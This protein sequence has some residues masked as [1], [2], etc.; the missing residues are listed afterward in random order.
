MAQG[1]K[2]VI[3]NHGAAVVLVL[4]LATVACGINESGWSE[5][6]IG[7]RAEFEAIFFLDPQHGL[8]VGGDYF[9]DGGIIGVT[10]DG[11]ATWSFQSGMVEAKAGFRLTDVE[12]LDRFTGIT[13]GTHGVI[14]RTEDRGRNWHPVRPYSGGTDHF[15]DLF[16][17]D[18]TYGWAVGFNGIV[19]TTDGGRNWAWLGERR[20]VAG[21]AVHFFDP[22]H[23]LVAGKHGRILL[24]TNGGESWTLVTETDR[25]GTADLLAMTFVGPTRGWTVGSD[26]TILHTT[27]AGRSWR[28]QI[29]HVPARLTAVVFVDPMQG[30]ALGAD[31]STSASVILHTTDGGATWR[32]DH[33]VE[34]ELLHGLFFFDGRIGWAVGERPEH[35]AQ[36]VMRYGAQ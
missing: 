33:V 21:R 14:L 5:E 23:G 29:S 12:F 19:H 24:T 28:C 17:L 4:C 22:N 10:S 31:R 8:I 30:W 26:G 27:D 25:T 2:F 3:S 6:R 1:S 11:G 35:G 16:F 20:A 36:V 34:D 7:T 32:T 15:L 18:D 13:I 9:V